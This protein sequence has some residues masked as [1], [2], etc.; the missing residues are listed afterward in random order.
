MI[1]Y[2]SKPQALPESIDLDDFI[3]A[4]YYGAMPQEML[5]YYVAPFLAVEQ[6]TGTWT[7]VPGETP[8]V[9]AA[10]VA[11]VIA[12]WEVPQWEFEV[13]DAGKER[14]YVIQIAFPVRNI[15]Y[16]IP[17]MLTATL[18][19]I[20]MAGKVK[21]LDLHFP[22]KYTEGF[23]GPKFGI[24]GIYEIL[25][26]SGRPLLNN[27]IK[28][29]TGYTCEIGTEL[30][31]QAARGGCDC[32]KD[33]E[34]IADML[35]NRVEDRVKA[36]M[37]MEKRVFEETGEHTLYTVNVSDNL[38]KMFETARRAVAAGANAIMVNYLAVG[39]PALQALAEDP[40]VNVP[41]MAHMDCAGALYESHYSGLSS[42]LVLGKLPR[43]AG[44]DIVV[45]PAPYGKAPFLKERFMPCA[46]AMV[47][48]LHNLKPIMPMPSGGI[49]PSMVSQCIADLGPEI[50]IGSGGG[51]HAHPAGPA[52]GATAFRQAIDAYFAGVPLEQYAQ[53]HQE[54]AQAI[55]VWGHLHQGNFFKEES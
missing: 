46:D 30:F 2:S 45:F 26:V 17:M 20:S 29:C 16:Q 49:T 25:G 48:P 19:N 54:L 27:M 5:A 31:Y 41:I 52:A 22:K 7:P 42:H 38:P 36:Y 55:G 3:V 1:D 24:D 14:Q 37:A 13:L 6:S 33:D 35:F 50:M 40:E 53:D 12:V 28:P 10:H 32:I 23:Q 51:I 4:T 21:L 47:Y 8:E 39:L 9:R 43:L 34:L 18:G 15:E 44:A 11:K